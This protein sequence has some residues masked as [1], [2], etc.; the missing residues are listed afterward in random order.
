MEEQKMKRLYRVFSIITILSLVICLVHGNLASAAVSSRL[1]AKIPVFK[2]TITLSTIDQLDDGACEFSAEVESTSPKDDIR[3]LKIVWGCNNPD[4]NTQILRAE[5]NKSWCF[6]EEAYCDFSVNCN[7]GFCGGLDTDNWEPTIYATVNGVKLYKEFDLSDSYSFSLN[8]KNL[9]GS[10]L[11]NA[12]NTEASKAFSG[13]NKN[14]SDF[15][16]AKTVHDYLV[17][18]TVSSASE[19]SDFTYYGVLLNHKGACEGYAAA[20]QMLL[21]RLGIPTVV[22]AGNVTG[23]TESHAWDMVELNHKW[24]HV[25]VTWDDPIPDQDDKI[26]YPYFLLND[27]QITELGHSNWRVFVDG[28]LPSSSDTSLTGLSWATMTHEDFN[29]LE[30][31]V[32]A[33]VSLDT[34]RYKTTVGGR[35]IFL[36]NSNLGEFISAKAADSTV[37]EVGT[38]D[39][40]GSG[41]L[42]PI[43]GLKSGST[44]ITATSTCGAT[45]SFPVVVSAGK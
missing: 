44:T 35:Y 18:H 3:K 36:A 16:K 38:P 22:V 13:L 28:S 27:S 25:D 17:T 4:Q 33:S 8:G 15:E 20:Y 12:V 24:Y 42:I 26:Q 10:A 21:K 1:S 23:Y 41:W 29:K 43:K 9:S 7:A 32:P 40:D 31:P 2:G 11:T 6:Q 14:M 19:S 30:T 34:S 39:Y 5:L 37:V 45:A